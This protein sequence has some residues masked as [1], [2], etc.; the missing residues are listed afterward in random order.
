LNED[1]TPKLLELGG[2]VDLLLDKLPS[3]LPSVRAGQVKPV[4][5]T[6]TALN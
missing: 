5:V 4:A 1:V 6:A 3:L 2:R